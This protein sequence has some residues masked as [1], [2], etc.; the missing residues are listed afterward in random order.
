MTAQPSARPCRRRCAVER[1]EGRALVRADRAGEQQFEPFGGV[2]VAADGVVQVVARI[3]LRGCCAATKP[4][5]S[6]DRHVRRDGAA[7][8]LVSTHPGTAAAL[9]APNHSSLT[10]ADA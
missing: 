4:P 1:V 10:P 3:T 9:D 2:V 7:R 6:L 5:P 8:G